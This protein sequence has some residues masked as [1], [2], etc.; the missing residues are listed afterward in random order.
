MRKFDNFN[1]R[2]LLISHLFRILYLSFV[3]ILNRIKKT[4]YVNKF[5]ISRILVDLVG[6]KEIWIEK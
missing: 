3:L 5:P 2:N 4:A 1:Q 6:R